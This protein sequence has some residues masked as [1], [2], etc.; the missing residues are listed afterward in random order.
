M[1]NQIRNILNRTQIFQTH[2]IRRL[3]SIHPI[4][5]SAWLGTLSPVAASAAKHAAHKTLSRITVTQ[6]PMNKSFYFNRACPVHPADFLQ[7]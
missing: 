7:R 4:R 3:L 2:N 6:C 5:Q 1:F